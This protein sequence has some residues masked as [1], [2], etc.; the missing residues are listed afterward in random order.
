MCGEGEKGGEPTDRRGRYGWRK[1]G[2]KDGQ[3]G[4]WVGHYL[5]IK[6][7]GNSRGLTSDSHSGTAGK[8][9]P[10]GRHETYTH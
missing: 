9:K 6:A 7:K 10:R 8:D 3:E 4:R 1:K 2:G 5:Q